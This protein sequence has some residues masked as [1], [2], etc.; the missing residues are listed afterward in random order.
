[1]KYLLGAC[2]VR[3]G[4]GIY[5]LGFAGEDLAVAAG[6]DAAVEGLDLDDL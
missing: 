5:Y 4:L 1:V 6:F 2:K 3:W